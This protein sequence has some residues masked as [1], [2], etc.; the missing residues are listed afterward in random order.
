MATNDVVR[1]SIG[2]SDANYTTSQL[3]R[4]VTT[5]ASRGTSYDLTLFDKV[6]DADGNV[7]E[8]YSPEVKGDMD[9]SDS[10]W[11]TVFEGMR[12]VATR[13]AILN[14]LDVAVAGKTGTAQEDYSR[15]S[16]G[17]F[18]GFAPYD[19]PEVAMAVRITNGY[20]SGNAISVA[21]DIF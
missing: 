5:I 1:S 8:D 2:Q 10:T 21:N 20:T 12:G 6:T 14:Y 17:L 18:I 13:N 9:V 16:H 11:S 15:P 7:L 4:Y 3:A 19:D